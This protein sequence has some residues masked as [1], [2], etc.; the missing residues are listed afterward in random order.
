MKAVLMSFLATRIATCIVVRYLNFLSLPANVLSG[1]M[2]ARLQQISKLVGGEEKI[3]V[4][5]L[6]LVLTIFLKAS[7]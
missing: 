2:S 7:K 3:Q 1:T 5:G 6:T 4:L